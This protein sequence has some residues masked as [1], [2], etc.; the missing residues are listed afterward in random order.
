MLV[1]RPFQLH[2]RISQCVWVCLC[3]CECVCVCVRTCACV[4]KRVYVSECVCVCVRER[5]NMRENRELGSVCVWRRG[6]ERCANVLF[7]RAEKLSMR[8]STGVSRANF[9]VCVWEGERGNDLYKRVREL[10]V[11]LCASNWSVCHRMPGR[12]VLKSLWGQAGRKGR[13]RGL[14]AM[15]V[16]IKP[17]T[18]AP[19]KRQRLRPLPPTH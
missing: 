15:L 3:V 1:L 13:R 10:R 19:R 8:A 12:S 9:S 5:E 2:P 16:V 7:S 18:P 14:G 4:W 6:R 11:R 17:H